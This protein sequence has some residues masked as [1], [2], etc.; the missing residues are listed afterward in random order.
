MV[1]TTRRRLLAGSWLA[2]VSNLLPAKLLAEAASQPEPPSGDENVRQVWLQLLERVSEPVLQAVS[3]GQLR[4]SM[5]VEAAPGQQAARAIGSPLEAFG[6]LLAGLAPW[7]EL[8]PAPGVDAA[9]SA[10]RH[11]YRQAALRGIEAA[12]DPQAADYMRFGQSSQTLVDSSFL[13]LALLR[14]PRQLI[15]PLSPATRAQLIAALEQER[16]IDPPFNNWLLF[17]AVN[18]A[19]LHRL[20]AKADPE[21]I[22]YALHELESWYLGDGTYGDGPRFH[23]DFYNSIVIHPYL[24]QL[25]DSVGDIEPGWKVLQPAIRERAS[26][27]AAIQERLISPRGEYPVLGRSIAYRA[28]AFHLLADAALRG[29]LPA[30]VKPAQVRGALTAVQ[31][32]TLLAPG[33]FSADG[34]LQ[35]GLCGHQPGLGET[36]ISTGSLYL[37][38]AAWLP[39]GLPPQHPFWATPAADWTQKAVW[40]GA[41]L[42]ADHA[43][44]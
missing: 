24:L 6:R 27:Y 9:E 18:E 4:A 41:D 2:A 32:R 35:I 1:C 5:P 40:A 42:A 44:D 3:K 21:R 20:G 38:S 43:L 25:I 15:G 10:L 30:A 17:A 11:R 29:L 23:A 16:A 22:A 19:L 36:Y 31:Q 34:W 33:T 28:G 8:D 39:L 7:L 14:A 37:A 12:V 13:A 26:R